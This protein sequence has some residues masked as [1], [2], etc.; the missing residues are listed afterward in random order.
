MTDETKLP[1]GFEAREIPQTEDA[2]FPHRERVRL[3]LVPDPVR[4]QAWQIN[5]LRDQE[6]LGERAVSPPV[7]LEQLEALALIG[8]Y[9]TRAIGKQRQ[10]VDA[11]G[12]SQL[13]HRSFYD[14]VLVGQANE[15]KT[16]RYLVDHFSYVCQLDI[17]WKWLRLSKSW[18]EKKKI[19]D[20]LQQELS[21]SHEQ[22]Q[23]DK[24]TYGEAKPEIDEKSTHSHKLH[25]LR[26]NEIYQRYAQKIRTLITDM[27]A[28]IKANPNQ[29]HQ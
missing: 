20:L 18:K 16:A 15:I 29:D 25:T 13:E 5:M 19:L 11:N 3:A 1:G 23:Q 6:E 22:Y 10:V 21:V 27:I 14:D 26:N 7:L 8:T 28:E 17:N 2:E 24:V 12:R 9:D 4:V